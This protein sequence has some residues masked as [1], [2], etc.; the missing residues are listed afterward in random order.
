MR[1]PASRSSWHAPRPRA[2]S[3]AR[4]GGWRAREERE[5]SGKILSGQTRRARKSGGTPACARARARSRPQDAAQSSRAR[6]AAARSR[7]PR[8]SASN[9][10]SRSAKGTTYGARS[11]SA[12]A[13]R[14][15]LAQLRVHARRLG[16]G[17]ASHAP[18]GAARRDERSPW[19]RSARRARAQLL[20]LG[21]LARERSG[22]ALGRAR[23]RRRVSPRSRG[24][25]ACGARARRAS[26][27]V[28][29]Q[30]LVPLVD[31]RVVVHDEHVR[32]RACR[33]RRA[34]SAPRAAA[35]PRPARRS[36]CSAR[37]SPRSSRRDGPRQ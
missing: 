24:R 3:C 29:R 9:A 20:A 18:G 7:A 21:A 32:E 17:T 10:R 16:V 23:R 15:A 22:R 26:Q 25:A 12:T 1:A 5:S 34:R 6:P 19:S 13:P 4:K 33:T 8:T 2:R 30:R 27:L 31:L 35:R 14:R 37:G 11:S 36:R 28:E